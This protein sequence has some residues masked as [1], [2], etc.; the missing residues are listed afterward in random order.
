M[1]MIA[2]SRERR[3]SACPLSRRSFGR[4]VPSDATTESRPAIRRNPQK[5]NLQAFGPSMPESLQSQMRSRPE[6]RFPLNGLEDFSRPTSYRPFLRSCSL[7]CLLKA[8]RT[9]ETAHPCR[10]KKN[11]QGGEPCSKNCVDPFSRKLN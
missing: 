4:I 3:R 6:N 11:E 10:A 1:L 5:M 8:A 2:S 7:H 9:G